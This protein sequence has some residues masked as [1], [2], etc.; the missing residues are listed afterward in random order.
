[1]LAWQVGTMTVG[2]RSFFF[3]FFLRFTISFFSFFPRSV[4]KFIILCFIYALHLAN[5]IY[6]QKKITQTCVL[7]ASLHFTETRHKMHPTHLTKLIISSLIHSGSHSP[8]FNLRQA[9]CIGQRNYK[10]KSTTQGQSD[11]CVWMR[12]PTK[13]TF[14]NTNGR[15]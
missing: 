14:P 13:P 1:M 11:P 7:G 8:T 2:G 12:S 6:H 4:N 10:Q 9:L 15:S 3:F 5:C